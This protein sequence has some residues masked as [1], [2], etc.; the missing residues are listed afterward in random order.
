MGER[1]G[2]F[3]VGRDGERKWFGGGTGGEL[4]LTCADGGPFRT[5]DGPCGVDREWLTERFGISEQLI[6]DVL[7]WWSAWQKRPVPPPESWEY[8]HRE[9]EHQLWQ[10]LRAAGGGSPSR[11]DRTLSS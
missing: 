10:R 11:D 1:W 4:S 6:N 9:Q 2:W 7:E 8:V 3:T 5:G